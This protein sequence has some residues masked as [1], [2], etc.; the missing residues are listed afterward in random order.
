MINLEKEIREQPSVLASLK[1]ANLDVLKEL[2]KEAKEKG[3]DN[4]YLIA[5][6][7]SD[8]ACTYAQYLFAITMGMNCALGTPSVFTQ[9]GQKIKFNNALVIGV[10]QSGRAEDVCE[11]LKSANEQGMTT[12][13]ITNY[14]DSL[15]GTNA[16]YHLFCNAGEEKSIAATKTFTS[17]MYLLAL[18]CAMWSENK[19]LNNALEAIPAQFE[20]ALDYLPQS[21]EEQV[22]KLLDYKEAVVLGRGLAYPIALEGALKILETN[23]MK[24]KGYTISDFYHGPVAQLHE[25][26]LAIVLAQTGVMLP[27]GIKMP[28]KL[29]TVKAN[30]VI[31][32][33]DKELANSENA[34][35][36]ESTGSEYSLMFL[37]AL[38]V[39]LIALK[40][41]IA[42]G[43]D[44]DKSDAIA[45]ITV[46]K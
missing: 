4:I 32:T 25:G 39:Q 37:M 42:K 13:A 23:K 34:I 26:D 31:I 30:S 20:K 10:S 43:I 12:V 16:K 46:T 1:N 22:A 15:L 24:V 9:Y 36:I 3:I 11:V 41:V 27:D 40:L 35:Y 5:R 14:K 44:P 17:Q 18:L 2:V 28:K 33:D 21:V 29:D 7:T 6:G 19:E 45:K 38:T 8:H